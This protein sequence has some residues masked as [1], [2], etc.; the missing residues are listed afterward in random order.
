[1]DNMRKTLKKYFIPHEENNYHPHILHTKRAVFYGLVFFL[2]KVVLV[3]FVIFLPNEVFVLPDVL[4]EE[5]KQIIALT[6]EVRAENGLPTLDVAT[7]LNT[8][9]QYKADDMSAKE[10]FAHTENNV[11]VSTWLQSAGYK[12][13]TAG[14]NLAVGYST[15]QDIV[16][17]WKNSPTHYAN[18][19]DLDFKDFGVG[20]SGGMYDGQATVFIAQH[21]ASP[22]VVVESESVPAV[23]QTKVEKTIVKKEIE[24]KIVEIAATASSVLSAKVENVSPTVAPVINLKAPTPVD[25]YIQAKS[26]LSPVTNIFAVSKNIYLVAI[27]FFAFVLILN[28]IIEVRRQHPH[29]IMQ[30]TGL[31][32]LLVAFWKF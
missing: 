15:A 7:K 13:E 27:F 24:Q 18:L 5:Q 8:S 28:I 19:I 20:L 17:A 1:M 3:T 4:A 14:E 2:A 25:K 6:N 12:Y 10:Y 9:A 16:E 32:A 23:A 11:T 30:T 22:L 29:V 31:I 26:V 21:L